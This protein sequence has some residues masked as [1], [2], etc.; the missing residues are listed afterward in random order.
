MAKQIK[1]TPFLAGID[2]E[3]FIKENNNIERISQEEKKEL[4]ENY[5]ALKSI[6]E[7][8]A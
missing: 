6:F 4:K 7:I 5:E 8:E 3:K 2:A 1:E